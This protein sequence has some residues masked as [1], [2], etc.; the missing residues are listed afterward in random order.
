MVISKLS[1]SSISINL[2][3]LISIVVIVRNQPFVCGISHKSKC[4]FCLPFLEISINWL[5]YIQVELNLMFFKGILFV[6]K[7]NF[8]FELL[9]GIWDIIWNTLSSLLL[10]HH[11]QIYFHKIYIFLALNRRVR[12]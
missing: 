8:I 10:F 6:K 2:Q 7:T 5:Q 4:L 11:S 1:D 9:L 12:Q 3:I